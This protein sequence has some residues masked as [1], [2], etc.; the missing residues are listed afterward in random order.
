MTS[1]RDDSRPFPSGPVVLSQSCGSAGD[2]SSAAGLAEGLAVRMRVRMLATE[3]AI[4]ETSVM[5]FLWPHELVVEAGEFF[6]V[7]AQVADPTVR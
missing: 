3:T 2:A 4:A 6:A 5:R 1:K 7:Q